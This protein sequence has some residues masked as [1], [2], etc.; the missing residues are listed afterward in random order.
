MLSIGKNI[1]DL[2]ADSSGHN[3]RR[4]WQEL[5]CCNSI[6]GYDIA[7]RDA[8]SWSALH[9]VER[10]LLTDRTNES[11]R[12]TEAAAT[13]STIHIAH[14]N[15]TAQSSQC[16]TQMKIHIS[17][18]VANPMG[19]VARNNELVGSWIM[20]L[21]ISGY[22]VYRSAEIRNASAKMTTF[23]KKRTMER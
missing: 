10:Q 13:T 17:M 15:E 22:R 21:Q 14:A 3:C 6:E 7:L 5:Q 1:C 9:I 16:G 4:D 12:V 11:E 19:I 18:S 8:S 20:T 2:C 23:N